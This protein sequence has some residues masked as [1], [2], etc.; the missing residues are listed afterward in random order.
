MQLITVI[1][2]ILSNIIDIILYLGLFILLNFITQIENNID[3]SLF[4]LFITYILYFGLPLFFVGNTIGKVLFG[5]KWK[6]SGNLLII[7]IKY[8]IYFLTFF[9]GFS[10]VSLITNFPYFKIDN[11]NLAISIQLLITISILDFLVFLFSLGK[12]HLLDYVLNLK[13]ENLEYKK[14]EL[15]SLTIILLFWIIFIF[16]NL[17]FL[18]LDLTIKK[19]NDSV[20]KDIYFEN[21]P[22][23]MFYGNKPFI[24]KLKSDSVFITSDMFSFLFNKVYN[25]KVLYLNLP[26]EI[27]NSNEDRYKV[28]KDLLIQSMRND[29][30]TGYNPKQTK[31]VLRSFK[32]GHFLEYYSYNYTYYFNNVE[33]SWGIYGGIKNDSLTVNK[34]NNFVNNVSKQKNK[35]NI[36]LHSTLYNNKYVI[37]INKDEIQF[38]KIH[39]DEVEMKGMMQLNF[40][41]QSIIYRANYW[42]IISGEIQDLEDDIF[43]LKFSR[44]EISGKSL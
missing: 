36:N 21:F 1:K 44:D 15:K 26:F 6:N 14:K 30:F 18:K 42:N 19:V 16:T 9:P 12:Y 32:E 7:N 2:R 11:Y 35:K 38:E 23:D 43:Y 28:C 37:N 39:F 33:S 10:L 29:I 25:Q 17:F 5:L 8:Y 41:P 20:S 22:E 40:P 31:I 27:F 13:L 4:L 24:V 34:Y 3:A